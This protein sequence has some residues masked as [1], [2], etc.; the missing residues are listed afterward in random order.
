[1]H[2]FDGVRYVCTNDFRPGIEEICTE[3][4][5]YDY[6]RVLFLDDVNL[7][8]EEAKAK[9]AAFI[10]VPSSYEFGFQRQDMVKTGVKYIVSS[11]REVT[12]QMIRKIN[13]DAEKGSL[14]TA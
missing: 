10:G 4:Y 3:F 14:W 6:R 11:I 9:G 8:G 13:D 5:N 1:V 7:V 12:E 2:F